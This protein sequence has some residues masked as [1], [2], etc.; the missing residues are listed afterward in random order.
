MQ[1]ED[2]AEYTF[3]CSVTLTA[4]KYK[5]NLSCSP[6]LPQQLHEQGMHNHQLVELFIG[7]AAQHHLDAF[8]TD[9]NRQ[10]YILPWM[11]M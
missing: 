2:I 3:S 7:W 1:Q 6:I 5:R 9:A 8:W 10:Q 4:S 11:C